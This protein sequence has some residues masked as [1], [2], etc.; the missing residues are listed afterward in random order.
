M[1]CEE[2]GYKETAGIGADGNL[3]YKCKLTEEEHFPFFECDIE[4]VRV[5]RDKEARL[6]TDQ[7]AA[8]KAIELLRD[9]VT[10][11]RPD[12]ELIYQKLHKI[13]EEVDSITLDE[14]IRYLEAFL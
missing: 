2:C 12:I 6:R 11:P 10:K 1:K 13:R 9:R 4:R 3:R 8:E 14:L 5:R 7:E